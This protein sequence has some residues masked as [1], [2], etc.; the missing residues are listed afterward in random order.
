MSCYYKVTVI[1]HTHTHTDT[2]SADNLGLQIHPSVLYV[3]Q[4]SS[5][6]VTLTCTYATS[7]QVG[8]SPVWWQNGEILHHQTTEVT[9]KGIHYSNI[10]MVSSGFSN[11]TTMSCSLAN[12]RYRT[13]AKVYVI[14]EQ[15]Q[16]WI[17]CT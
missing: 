17:P 2:A 4:D 1:L 9:L 8:A 14:G 10:T 3:A 7:R 13:T 15:E 12:R 6:R 16:V 11:S 5:A